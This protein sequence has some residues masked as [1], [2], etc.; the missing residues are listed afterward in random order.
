M[1]KL[2]RKIRQNL[3]SE[4]KT[5]SYLKY[6]VGEI[7]L[8]MIGI[9]LALQVNNWN[10][11]RI[12]KE[13]LIYALDKI[14][15]DLNRDINFL[16]NI[17]LEG[18]KLDSLAKTILSKT[19]KLD[20]MS[21]PEKLNLFNT[22]LQYSPFNYATAGYE[23][24][25]KLDRS[26]PNMYN[27]VIE[28]INTHYN[29]VAPILIKLNEKETDEI[30]SHHNYL[31][32]NESWYSRFRL[33]Q[34]TK[35]AEDFFTSDPVYLNWITQFKI[36]SSSKKYGILHALRGSAI[37]TLLIVNKSLG[38]PNNKME[39]LVKKVPEKFSMISGIY[40]SKDENY[41]YKV[42]IIDG[43]LLLDGMVYSYEKELEFKSFGFGNK[44]K[45]MGDNRSYKLYTN[46]FFKNIEAI[47]KND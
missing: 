15:T 12:S 2:F 7:I 44:L 38:K 9:L 20:E 16:D 17:I 5:G 24:I 27:E 43:F 36:S 21:V 22:G 1:I 41:N 37:A 31:A 11:N 30:E 34:F 3:L 28:Q 19:Y 25:N 39:K 4:G 14:S 40:Y 10:D 8:V 23:K 29:S 45:F 26:I 32:Q 13:E 42:K 33:G 35:E 47:K 18:D 6:A 46:N